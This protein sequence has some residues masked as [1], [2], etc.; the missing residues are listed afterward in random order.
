MP[1]VST[2]AA[3]V[4]VR[5]PGRPK[6]SRLV[7]NREQLI[8][9]AVR[10]VRNGGPTATMDDVA[11]EANV[12][13]PIVY[14]QIGD[15]AALTLALSEWLIDQIE[16]AT[17]N[18]QAHV[19]DPRQRFR[20]AIRAY[21]ATIDEHRNVFLFVNTGGHTSELFGRLVDRSARGL[22]ELFEELRRLAGL[23]PGGARA[24]AYSIIGSLQVVATMWQ[25]DRFQELDPLADDLTR[26]M[27]DGLGAAG[28]T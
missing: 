26:L 6:G 17:T 20:L 10:A 5:R 2:D 12:S 27:W 24:W 18:A 15:K 8:D 23:D 22:V 25:R 19:V 21:L 1:A 11:N 3:H 16:A 28:R 7:A 9:A 13:K 14:R 4:H